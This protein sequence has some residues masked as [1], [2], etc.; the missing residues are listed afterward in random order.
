MYMFVCVSVFLHAFVY[1]CVDV[2]VFM[3][4]RGFVCVRMIDVSI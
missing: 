4:V 2:R 3:C 1:C